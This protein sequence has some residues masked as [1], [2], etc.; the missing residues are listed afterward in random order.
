MNPARPHPRPTL[1]PW[2]PSP[3]FAALWLALGAALGAMAQQPG[4]RTFP[5]PLRACEALVRAAQANDGQ[6]LIS[7]L[8]SGGRNVLASGDATEDANSRAQ[9]V[10]KYGE[11]HH[12]G[13]EKDG[14]R[15]L[16]VG[17]RR[18]PAPIP[19]RRHGS[20]WYFDTGAGLGEI[21]DRR[22]GENETSTI[23]TCQELAMAQKAYFRAKGGQYAQ[24]FVSAVGKQDGLYW[25]I[26]DGEP[27]SPLAPLVARA[28]AAGYPILEEG[29]KTPYCGYRFR[30][31][32]GQG[33]HA[34]GGAKP[35]LQGG[36]MTRGFAFLAYP[37][38]YRS[39]GMRSFLIG[40]DGIVYQQDLGP[41]TPARAEALR[42]YEPTPGW[43]QLPAAD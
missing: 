29:L 19:L 22:I 20:A 7:I 36:R 6:A 10:E 23:R 25:Q 26:G 38:E 32:T 12:L 31:L 37:A 40:Q 39:S 8:G 2:R 1:P 14:S 42:T 13:V 3:R 35:Y 34:P 21:L 27:P 33:K 11:R 24:A 15:V 43:E 9:F 41:T 30:F 17:L 16:Y 18:W 5:T 28:A 4:Q